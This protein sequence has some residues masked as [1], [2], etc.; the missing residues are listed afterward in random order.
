MRK[1]TAVLLL[2]IVGLMVIPFAVMAQGAEGRGC[3]RKA[4]LADAGSDVDDA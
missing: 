1:V 4:Q 3:L 2:P